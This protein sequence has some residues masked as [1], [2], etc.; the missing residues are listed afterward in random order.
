MKKIEL[1]YKDSE[2]MIEIPDK[3]LAGILN[4]NDLPEVKNADEEIIHALENPIESKP[5]CEL[6]RGKHNIVILVS[7]ITRP[8]PSYILLPPIIEELIRSGADYDNITIVFGLGYHR[9]QT[10][11][12]MEKL[13]GHSIYNKVKCIN[14]DIDDCINIG[15]TSRG[16]PVDVFRPVAEADF[17]IATGNLEF[18]YK[19]GYSGGNKAVLPGV[20]SKRTIESNHIMMIKPGTMP[21]KCEKNPMREDIDEA[22]TL[23]GVDFMVNAILNSHKKIVKVV[24]GHPIKAHREGTQYID[25]MYKIKLKKKVDIVVASCGGYPKDINLYQSQKGLENASYA[26]KDGGSIILL[27][28]CKDGLGEKLFEEWMMKAKN[29]HEPVK[30][31]QENF[32][33]GAHKAA[34]ICTVLERIKVYLVSSM[35]DEIVKNIFMHPVK[36]PQ[37]GLDIA[38]KEYGENSSVLVIPYANSV[39]PYVED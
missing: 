6:A 3:N 30:W 4:S 14:H 27:A 9:K 38:L 16:T 12:E 13:V 7:D 1:K 35:S 20:C 18:H 31:I 19:A 8:V 33:L 28:E 25:K 39:L 5:L 26:V 2:C 36:S 29:T 34:V 24:A 22:G 10:K 11:E 23:A 21:G 17:I 37:E 32:M 15:T